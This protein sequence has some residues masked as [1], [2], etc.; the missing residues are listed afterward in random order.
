MID[1]FINYK[2]KLVKFCKD[3]SQLLVSTIDPWISFVIGTP[4]SDVIKLW[5]AY[6]TVWRIDPSRL[7]ICVSAF[8]YDVT[9]SSLTI[10]YIKWDKTLY[11][12][13]LYLFVSLFF[14]SVCLSFSFPH[15]LYLYL[16]LF[17]LLFL[18]LFLLSFFPLTIYI[19]S[20][21][22]SRTYL[23]SCLFLSIFLSLPNSLSLSV[24][25]SLS[26]FLLIFSEPSAFLAYETIRVSG[27]CEISELAISFSLSIKHYMSVTLSLC[28]CVCVCV[29]LSLS[30]SL[31]LSMSYNYNYKHKMF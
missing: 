6:S 11:A 18:C 23:L 3:Q 25:L 5:I 28:M 2:L 4:S 10:C 27:T 26:Q 8:R 14:I 21:S 24:C 15:S 29:S 20:F 17:L 13:C 9:M 12:C 30:L 22:L 19:F 7:V 16:C 1:L 31:S